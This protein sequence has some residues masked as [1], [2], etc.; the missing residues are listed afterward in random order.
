MKTKICTKCGEEKLLKEFS[1]EKTGKFRVRSDCKDCVNI[2]SKEYTITH[3]EQ[4]KKYRK[5]F[6]KKNSEK[7]K[8]YCKQY[9]RLNKEKESLRAKEYR[10]KNI[11]RQTKLHT[12]YTRERRR[13]DP[14]F[15]LLCNLRNRMYDTI[16]KGQ[17]SLN[18][19]FLIGCEID[20]LMFHIQE[21]F[22]HDMSW[23]N[24]GLW[25]IDHIKPCAKFD[26]SKFEEQLKCFNFKNLQPLWAIDNLSKGSK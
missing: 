14:E 15:K 13:N 3:K 9:Y 10:K 6:N 17:K 1:K 5:E 20:Y 25:H 4:R 12:I 22:T 7:N 16:S 21:Q 2:W 24:Y 26:L 23:D 18:T 19:M 8:K 11:K